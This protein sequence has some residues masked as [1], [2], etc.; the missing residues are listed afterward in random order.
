MKIRCKQVTISIP[1]KFK[2]KNKKLLVICP[3]SCNYTARAIN[4]MK[5][6][7]ELTFL[8]QSWSKLVRYFSFIVQQIKSK[9]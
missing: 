5:I 9:F 2:S 3:L 8:F 7:H 6:T 1:A 4:A